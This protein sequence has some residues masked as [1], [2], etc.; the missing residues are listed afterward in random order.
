[1]P[2]RRTTKHIPPTYAIPTLIIAFSLIGIGFGAIGATLWSTNSPVIR[3]G[4][5]SQLTAP[6]PIS[7]ANVIVVPLPTA[8]RAPLVTPSPTRTATPGFRSN[9]PTDSEVKI[10]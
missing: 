6:S 2:A 9:R 5:P 4:Y 1:M 3:T 8:T 10:R 7:S